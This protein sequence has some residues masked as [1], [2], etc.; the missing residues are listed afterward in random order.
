MIA[1]SL[2]TGALEVFSRIN[3]GGGLIFSC[4]VLRLD[5]LS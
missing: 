4:P 5:A 3:I 2:L 1:A